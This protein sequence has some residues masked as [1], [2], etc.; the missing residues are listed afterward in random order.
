MPSALAFGAGGEFRSP[1][2]LAVIG[3]LLFSTLLSLIFV[4]A[5]FMMMDDVGRLSWRL[6]KRLL[7]SH[8]EAELPAATLSA[9]PRA[10]EGE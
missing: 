9:A 2:A 1:M 7:T 3:G 6:G 5:M 4:P 8:S 10:L